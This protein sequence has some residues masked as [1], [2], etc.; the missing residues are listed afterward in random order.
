LLTD[1]SEAFGLDYALAFALMSLAW[2]PGQA[3]GSSLSGAVA[4]AT[5]DAVPYLGVATVTFVTF[6][7]VRARLP[8]PA[9]A[10]APVADLPLP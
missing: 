9:R 3:I 6:V 8:R 4:N 10:G 5:S 1:A 2:A 7:V